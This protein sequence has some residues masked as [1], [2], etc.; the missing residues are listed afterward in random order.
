MFNTLKVR[1]LNMGLFLYFNLQKM[2]VQSVDTMVPLVSDRITTTINFAKVDASPVALLTTALVALSYM[3]RLDMILLLN[4]DIEM[5][6][7]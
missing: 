6:Q 5:P 4:V 7:P 3:D 2:P 1:S